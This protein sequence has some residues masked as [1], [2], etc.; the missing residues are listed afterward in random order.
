MNLLT[1]KRGNKTVDIQIEKQK[2]IV[3][4][5]HE[6]KRRIK[7]SIELFFSGK[8][9]EYRKEEGLN[10]EILIDGKIIPQKTTMFHVVDENY[11][12]IE[13]SKLQASSLMTKYFLANLKD[14]EYFDTINTLNFLFESLNEEINENSLFNPVFNQIIDKQ[15]IKLMSPLYCEELAKDEYDLSS[16]ELVALQ[17]KMISEILSKDHSI[18]RAILL[19]DTWKLTDEML[20]IIDRFDS[21]TYLLL[22]IEEGIQ[23]VGYS[24]IMII[25]QKNYVDLSDLESIYLQLS[26]KKNTYLTLMEVKKYGRKLL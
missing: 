2:V 20:E 22:F 6:L 19:I 12:I 16:A 9:S 3:G 13:D 18:E 26:E 8:T 17:L 5:E 25:D 23:K 7:K 4:C 21:R 15:L 10:A 11:S 14:S 1:I 24:D